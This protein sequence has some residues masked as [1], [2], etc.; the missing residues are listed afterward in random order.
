[1]AGLLDFGNPDSLAQLGLIGGL[2]TA[3]KGSNWPLM[4]HQAAQAQ[5]RRKL[6]QAEEEQRQMQMAQMKQAQAEQ[7]KRSQALQALAAQRPDLAQL[8]QLSPEAGVQRAFPAP[9]KPRGVK[10]A[11]GERYFEDGRE[12]F[13]VPEKTPDW[14]NP[15]Y[16]AAQ[17]EMRA[18][19]APKVEVN[20]AKSLWAGAADKVGDQIAAAPEVARNASKQSA[21]AQQVLSALDSGKVIAGPGATFRIAGGQLA[22]ALGMPVDNASLIKT[23][24][25]IQGF[26]KMALSARGALKGQGQISDFEG[27]LL[28][29][30]EAGNIDDLSVPEIRRLAQLSDMAARLEYKRAT[31]MLEAV[32]SDPV[33]RQLSPFLDPG[34][35]APGEYKAPNVIDFGSLPR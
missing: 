20:T 32:K 5:E 1:M 28:Q 23:R 16:I 30:A 35:N 13:A 22:S 4:L 33:G 29:K 7:E 15:A 26:A 25:V 8:L 24:E 31:Q 10:M 19:G 3:Q 6:M 12:I 14:Q 34:A 27:K 11:P 2:L 17:K 18:A 9:E 21:Y